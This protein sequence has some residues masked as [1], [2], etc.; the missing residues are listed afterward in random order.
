M[1]KLYNFTP[2]DDITVQELAQIFKVLMN[3]LIQCLSQQDIKIDDDLQIE[4]DVYDSLPHDLKRY[5][6]LAKPVLDD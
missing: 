6:I 1:N 4:D 2:D 5:F 3:I